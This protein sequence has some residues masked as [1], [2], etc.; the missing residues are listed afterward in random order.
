MTHAERSRR[1]GA[2][3]SRSAS[4]ANGPRAR[5]TRSRSWAGNS[6]GSSCASPHTHAEAGNRYATNPRPTECQEVDR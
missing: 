4:S 1:C 5:N 6:R 2:E 3:S